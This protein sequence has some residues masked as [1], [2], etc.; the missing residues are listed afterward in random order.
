MSQRWRR[1]LLNAV[2][3]R[4][5]T[6]VSG[7]QGLALAGSSAAS[8]RCQPLREELHANPE[9]TAV[10]TQAH[11]EIVTRSFEPSILAES[12]E[13]TRQPLKGIIPEVQ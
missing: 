2:R 6:G 9:S 8:Q 11:G 10:R 13:Q 12:H 7:S 1:T 3:V 4:S 5:S